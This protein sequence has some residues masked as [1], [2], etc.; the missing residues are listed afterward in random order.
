MEAVSL[1]AARLKALPLDP[2]H[3]ELEPRA[4]LVG[5]FVRDALV[6][7]KPKDA[8]V[9][10][11]GVMP[12]RLEKLL[13]QYFPGKVNRVGQRFEVLNVAVEEGITFDVSIPRR[14]SKTG[15]GHGG[16]TVTGDPSM[17]IEDAA[18]R[19]DFTFNALAADPLTG[20]VFD[21][22]NG[23]E[24]LKKRVLRMTDA[25]SFP[26]DHLRV[27]RGV[28][29][30]ARLN[31][32]V[33]PETFALMKSMVPEEEMT[34]IKP[35]SITKEWEKLLLKSDEP[36]RGLE[37]ARELGIIERFYP[38]LH[39][40]IG[41]QQEQEWH[42]E[43]DVW[44]HTMKVADAA[45]KIIRREGFAETEAL[46]TMVGAIGH[47]LGKPPTTK[48]EN[49]RWRSLAHEE[50]GRE[51]VR[52]MLS[53]H[54]F[55]EDVVHAA[56]TIAAE[57]LKPGMLYASLMKGDK[58]SGAMTEKSYTNAV[59]KLLRRIHPLS[60]RV[61]VAASEADS[62]G[63]GN[64]IGWD[65][66]YAAGARFA[67]AVEQNQLGT[68]PVGKLVRGEDILSIAKEEDVKIK[69][70]KIF[71]TLITA[72]EAARDAGTVTTKEEGL[73]LLRQL[74]LEAMREK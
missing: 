68:D 5:G 10:V 32:T 44:I 52:A 34:L 14:D 53:R 55:G 36:S 16:F 54:T 17:S 12:E 59:R 18:R 71:G 4:L 20:E 9:E 38:E 60:W 19:R 72:V 39:A 43:G 26:E 47:D 41:T 50:A 46:Q 62:R 30:T 63:R 3:P 48:F 15:K 70:G 33:D 56:E 27:Y 8:D 57:H 25:K 37:L 28:Q 58:T 73:A 67:A 74:F 45:A 51:P 66:P 40:L 42:P 7:V 49:G 11:Y 35:D 23:I 13:Q 24:D 21:Y 31:L 69:P 29:F 1:L 64:A 22:F 6:D 65:E 2:E 61:L